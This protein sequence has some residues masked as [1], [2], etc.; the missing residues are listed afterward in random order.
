MAWACNF[1]ILV[2][3]QLQRLD[4]TI[5]CESQPDSTDERSMLTHTDES[6]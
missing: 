4:I 5:S 1:Q 3:L 6:C 2:G